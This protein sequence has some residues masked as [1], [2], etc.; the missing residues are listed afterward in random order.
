MAEPVMNVT[1]V[2]LADRTTFLNGPPHEY[3]EFLRR[4]MPVAWVDHLEEDGSG[5]W[6][7]TKWDDVMEVERDP[8]LFSSNLGGTMIEPLGGGVELMMLNQDPPRHTRLKLLVSRLFTPRHIRSIEESIRVA[9]RDIVDKVAPK[10]EIDLVTEVSAEMPLIVIAELLG[11]PQEDRHKVFEWSN[12]M[13]GS[14]DPEYGGS[15]DPMEA[16]AELYA[17]AQ[18]LAE[19]RLADP[20]EDVVTMLLTGEVDGEKLDA[21]EFNLFFL[22]LA[23]AGNETT[24][25]LITGGVLALLDHPDERDRLVQDHALL[26]TAVEEMLRW[27]S[28]VNYFRRTATRAT[29]IR[30]VPIAAGDKVT[31]WYGAANRDE[32]KFPDAGRFDVGRSPN[33]HVAF[34]GRGPHFCLGANLA[35]LEITVM[36]EELLRLLPDMERTGPV[37]RLQMNLI[38]GIKHMPVKFASR[39]V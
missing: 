3:F 21:M 39:P 36:F 20:G 17:Y 19:E 10:G 8:E 25:N 32:D 31:I 26:P 5:Y 15:R 29:E 11:V 1:D 16:A 34:G 4:E 13:V 6:V 33:E 27:V 30:G 35:R 9:A 28:P 37:E 22:L 7:V 14:E 18:K 2:D 23:V 24:R 12:A 38:N